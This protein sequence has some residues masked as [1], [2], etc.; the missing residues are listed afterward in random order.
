MSADISLSSLCKRRGFIATF[1]VIFFRVS[2]DF[3]SVLPRQLLLHL[4]RLLA[5]DEQRIF[6][7]L[8]RECY[9]AWRTLYPR[10][11]PRPRSLLQTIRLSQQGLLRR[12][13]FF[14]HGLFGAGMY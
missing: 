13:L 8:N 10:S 6:R 11:V 5:Y 7:K 14:I 2:D 12:V 4:M 3:F 1:P 9:A